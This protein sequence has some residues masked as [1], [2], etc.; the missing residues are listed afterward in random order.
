MISQFSSSSLTSC[1]AMATPICI[2]ASNVSKCIQNVRLPYDIVVSDVPGDGNCWL[3]AFSVSLFINYGIKLET[4]SIRNTLSSFVTNMSNIEHRLKYPSSFQMIGNALNF[5]SVNVLLKCIAEKLTK[6]NKYHAMAKIIQNGTPYFCSWAGTFQIELQLLCTA[7]KSI[8]ILLTERKE[9]A[10]TFFTKPN[11]NSFIRFVG[12]S[13]ENMQ[14]SR[15]QT[16]QANDN[17]SKFLVSFGRSFNIPCLSLTPKTL[18]VR[19]IFYPCGLSKSSETMKG[20]K[21]ALLKYHNNNHYQSVFLQK[22]NS[23]NDIYEFLS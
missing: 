21:I 10:K 17:E 15:T 9:S 16:N 7:F 4:Q 5:Y 2:L 1:N 18:Y 20:L 22:Q 3:Y 23:F 13:D 14:I 8:I 6:T 19:S 11:F 12:L